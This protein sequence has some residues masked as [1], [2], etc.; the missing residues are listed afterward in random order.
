MSGEQD[1]YNGDAKQWS[2]ETEVGNNAFLLCPSVQQG[3]GFIGVT[4]IRAV[5]ATVSSP[6]PT[7]HSN[8]QS[9][10]AQALSLSLS[11]SLSLFFV[12]WFDFGLI[13]N[14]RNDSKQKSSS[15]V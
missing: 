10:E 3:H 13:E 4:V 14:E 5:T 1:W 6:P 2:T 11:L 7:P 15:R 12:L 8:A 9:L